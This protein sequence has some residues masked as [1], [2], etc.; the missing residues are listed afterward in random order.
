MGPSRP[1]RAL[2][3]PATHHE[4]PAAR[5]ARNPRRLALHPLVTRLV[6]I[7]LG[8]SRPQTACQVNAL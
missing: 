6:G 8:A 5:V 4:A 1:A 2:V 7:V 3:G